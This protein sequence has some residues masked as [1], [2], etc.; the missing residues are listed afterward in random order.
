MVNRKSPDS[1]VYLMWSQLQQTEQSL[2]KSGKTLLEP[3]KEPCQ[4]IRKH[5]P[6]DSD[7]GSLWSH[8]NLLAG[9]PD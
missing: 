2:L 7:D 4:T 5:L 1:D 6:L 9:K 8:D 3:S